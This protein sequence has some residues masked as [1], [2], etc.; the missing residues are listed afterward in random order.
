MEADWAIEVGPDLP[1]IDASWEGFVDLQQF[2]TSIHFIQEAEQHPALKHA[3]K[4]LNTD[5]SS[6]YTVKCDAWTL[7][8]AEIDPSEFDAEAHTSKH[9]FASYIDVLEHDAERFAS[10]AWHEQRAQSI[11]SQLKTYALHCGRIDLV[12]RQAIARQQAGYGITIYAAGCG[13]TNPTACLA[14]QSMLEAAIAATIKAATYK[15]E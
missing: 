2:P 13:A 5:G 10:F 7:T 3:L 9:G 15:G 14:W 11:A 4:A 12:V 8:Q 1:C 6:L